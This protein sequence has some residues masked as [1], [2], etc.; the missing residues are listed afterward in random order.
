LSAGPDTVKCIKLKRSQ[1]AHHIV[2]TGNSRIPKKV[3]NRKFRGR[4][5]VARPGLRREDVR[6]DSLLLI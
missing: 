3:L 5:P 4:R 1:Y 2:R 6:R